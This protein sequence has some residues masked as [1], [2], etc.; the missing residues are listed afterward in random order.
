MNSCLGR[1][2]KIG[3]ALGS[4]SA[5]GLAHIGVIRALEEAG[6]KVGCV[7]GTSIG[8]LIGS[9]Y[10]SGKLDAL[11]KVY[12]GFDWKKIAYFFDVVFP[13]SGLIDG[14]KVADFVREYVHTETIEHL[15]LPFQAVATDIGTGEEVS[16]DRGD[17]IEAVRASISV[18][19]IFTPVRRNSRVLVDG[20]LVNPV[21]VSTARSMG[22]NIVIAVDLNHD[23]VAGKV[24]EAAPKSAGESG[25]V[26]ALSRMGGVKYLAAMERINLELQSL[27]NPALNQIRAWLAEESLPNIFE[28]LLSSINVME[29]QITRTRLHIDPPDLLIRPQLGHIR[30]LEFNRAEEIINIGYEEA[31]RQIERESDNLSGNYN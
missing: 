13:K 1:K 7:A 29:T 4:G 18:P 12:L 2:Q 28:V 10:A 17:V 24:P 9:V 3:L 26:Q 15:P 5:R 25:F 11:E 8:S 14:K 30:F 23:I 20:G 19:G 22:A 27:E 16:L 31:R 6:I 21:P